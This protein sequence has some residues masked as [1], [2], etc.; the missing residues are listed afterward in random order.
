MTRAAKKRTL[1]EQSQ[2]LRRATTR[3]IERAGGWFDTGQTN[4]ITREPYMEFRSRP[5]RGRQRADFVRLVSETRVLAAVARALVPNDMAWRFY[6]KPMEA[7]LDWLERAE[8]AFRKEVSEYAPYELRQA[9]EM[10]EGAISRMPREPARLP[11]EA[12]ELA[13]RAD[14]DVEARA[15]L[16][17]LLEERG[18]ADLADLV[19]AREPR[20]DKNLLPILAGETALLQ[21][22]QLPRI[23]ASRR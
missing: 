3:L 15:V 18:R 6:D 8:Y 10:V 19:R 4:W 16:A 14:A 23:R 1:R 7:V 11:P 2:L 17:D 13:R 5:L 21:Q 20:I 9:L 12:R 22:A